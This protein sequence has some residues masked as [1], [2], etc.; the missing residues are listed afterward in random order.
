MFK[1]FCELHKTMWKFIVYAFVKEGMSL[2]AILAVCITAIP[3]VLFVM[4]YGNS[5]AAIIV[6]TIYSLYMM[7]GWAAFS[8]LYLSDR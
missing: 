3:V 7:L 6:N 1:A 2:L 4:L 5:P 8:M